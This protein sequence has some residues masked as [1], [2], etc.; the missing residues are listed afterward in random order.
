[1]KGVL[2]KLVASATLKL[3]VAYAARIAT[4]AIAALKGIMSAGTLSDEARR[5]IGAVIVVLA[6]V[7]DFLNRL[8]DI[9]GAPALPLGS[10]DMTSRMIDAA[11]QLDKIT[12]S[13]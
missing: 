10:T 4:T 11:E 12:D 13:L 8:S 2:L 9:I 3:G 7:S 5:N 1:M 6:A